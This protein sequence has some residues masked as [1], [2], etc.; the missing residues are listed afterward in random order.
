MDEQLLKLDE[1][2]PLRLIIDLVKNLW[3]AVLLAAAVWLGISAYEKLNYEPM[4]TST[5]TLV[6][7]AKGG[8]GAYSSLSLTSN[9]AEVF[10]GVFQSNVLLEKVEEQLGEPLSGYISTRTVPN[11][12]LM[13][14]SLTSPNQEEAFR[15]LNLVIETYPEIA[16]SMFG[17][18]VLTVLKEPAIPRSPSNTRDT[19]SVQ[20][21]ATVVVF[22]LSLCAIAALSV[23]RDTVQT[24]VAAKRWVDGLLLRPV[25]HE[26]KNKTFR[27]I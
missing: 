4:Y 6:V 16:E 12:N 19:A 10:A 24:P 26:V 17:N 21:M 11:T 23:L 2:N 5:A 3:V 9:M 14:L 13:V 8:S 27:A 15:A 18:A 7:S 25:R 1:I 22:V 20:K